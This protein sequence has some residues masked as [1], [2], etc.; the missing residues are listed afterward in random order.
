MIEVTK[1]NIINLLKLLQDFPSIS[2][3]DIQKLETLIQQLNGVRNINEV[4]EDCA[5]QDFDSRFVEDQ[6]MKLLEKK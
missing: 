6:V 5:N 3:E 1:D 4:L 2:F